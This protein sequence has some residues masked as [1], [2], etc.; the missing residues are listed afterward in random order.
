MGQFIIYGL[1]DPRTSEVRYV[2]L[3]SKGMSRPRCHSFPFNLAKDG[4]THK[5]NWIRGLMDAGLVY[6]ILVLEEAASS[7]DLPAAERRWIAH[8]RAQG[9]PLTNLTDGGEGQLGLV[10]TAEA[11]AK[12]SASLM[13][14][15]CPT[16][17]K[18]PSAETRAKMSASHKGH[19]V[20]AETRAK[21][22]ATQKGKPMPA[23]CVAAARANHP[24]GHYFSDEHRANVS[25]GLM[26]HP[27]SDETR[28][29]LRAATLRH[30]QEK[31][32]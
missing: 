29:K 8:G 13:G 18:H 27:V 28:A 9:W 16:K 5:A 30:N 26:G 14:R 6:G 17:G 20:S 10:H 11:K 31:R 12:I 1:T 2:G 15:P 4:K 25:N 3:S 22:S 32:G 21:R 23:A 24:R 7:D 19:P